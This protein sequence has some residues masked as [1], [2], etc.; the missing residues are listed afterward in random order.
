MNINTVKEGL[1]YVKNH[2]GCMYMNGEFW[3]IHSNGTCYKF[4]EK[5][6]NL[7]RSPF[8]HSHTS[9]RSITN[10]YNGFEGGFNWMIKDLLTSYLVDDYGNA[11]PDN[12]LLT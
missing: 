9:S 4:K 8:S 11:L 12:Y 3:E 5:I 2:G 1:E 6:T 7:E 10:K